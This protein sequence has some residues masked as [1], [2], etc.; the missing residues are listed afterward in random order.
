MSSN[1]NK[2]YRRTGK[3]GFNDYYDYSPVFPM[4]KE[5]FEF[6]E[7]R[8][9]KIVLGDRK[10][11]DYYG[12]L[13]VP[14]SFLHAFMR[15]KA[16][17]MN[18]LIYHKFKREYDMG[19][20]PVYLQWDATNRV[21]NTYIRTDWLKAKV[22]T[23][24]DFP[25]WLSKK[26]MFKKSKIAKIFIENQTWATAHGGAAPWYK[27]LHNEFL[28]DTK[29]NPKYKQIRDGHSPK[30]IPVF[31]IEEYRGERP[32][33]GKKTFR[34]QRSDIMRK[35]RIGEATRATEN[36]YRQ[37][38]MKPLQDDDFVK[39][40][41]LDNSS[42][43]WG[44]NNMRQYLTDNNTDIKKYNTIM[45]EVQA[46]LWEQIKKVDFQ[47]E[48]NHHEETRNRVDEKGVSTGE[49]YFLGDSDSKHFTVFMPEFPNIGR[50]RD[51]FVKRGILTKEPTHKFNA[52]SYLKLK[53][54][55]SRANFIDN[56]VFLIGLSIF[57]KSGDAIWKKNGVDIR[58]SIENARS[59]R[60]LKNPLR[61]ADTRQDA[62]ER[63]Q[64]KDRNLKEAQ[65]LTRRLKRIDKRTQDT[66]KRRR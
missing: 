29:D 41:S 51:W 30:G 52:E 21:M 27:K 38:F 65:Y 36:W 4:L 20:V 2:S 43:I 57:E 40:L 58:S 66:R 61:G 18:Q 59:K 47:K 46:I 32:T 64:F 49:N 12:S 8:E 50:I 10:N 23:E 28:E 9:D 15:N 37:F 1:A 25:K 45:K 7:E 16:K 31:S 53:S 17:T 14:P 26:K 34:G 5:S 11:R 44:D 48:W 62:V 35:E 24:V 55:K 6:P 22:H 33:Q 60:L 19:V 13:R 3:Q 56:A 39:M 63:R 54:N 42:T